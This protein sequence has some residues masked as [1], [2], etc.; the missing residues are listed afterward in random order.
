MS[1]IVHWHLELS[2][3]IP[4]G[5][6]DAWCWE[7][8]RWIWYRNFFWFRG[9]GGVGA[10]GWRVVSKMKAALHSYFCIACIGNFYNITFGPFVVTI[11]YVS[12]YMVSGELFC[13]LLAIVQWIGVCK[14]LLYAACVHFF[15]RKWRLRS[16]D[17]KRYEMHY[18]RCQTIPKL[19]VL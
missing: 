10:G 16:M 3:V 5:W 19:N 9:R 17:L 15:Y 12:Y 1:T 18:R 8:F 7:W 4:D 11:A 2:Q 6:F 14:Q 13:I